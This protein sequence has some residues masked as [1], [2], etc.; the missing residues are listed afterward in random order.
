MSI[1]SLER[2]YCA[3]LCVL[4][5]LSC[6]LCSVSYCTVSNCTVF[7][8]PY[9]VSSEEIEHR[10]KAALKYRTEVIALKYRTEVSELEN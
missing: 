2:S 10:L 6:T 5:S 3:V 9:A 1:E 8:L 4:C 7:T